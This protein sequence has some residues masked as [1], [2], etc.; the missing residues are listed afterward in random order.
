ML[1]RNLKSNLDAL[2]AAVITGGGTT[3]G[4]RGAIDGVAFGAA[5]EVTAAVGI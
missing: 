4:A 1:Y 2:W 5:A 3:A